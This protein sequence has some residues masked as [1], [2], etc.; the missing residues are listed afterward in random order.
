MYKI[1]YG[2]SRKA[3]HWKNSTITWSKLKERLQH[4]L[5]TAETQVEYAHMKSSGRSIAKDKGGFVAGELKDGQRKASTVVCRS[6]LT[7]DLDNAKTTF[8]EDYKTFSPYATLIYSTHS[9][10][11]ESPRLRMIIP[12]TREITPDE[13]Q[14]VTRLFAG[15]QGIGQFDPCSFIP[16]Q[17]MF[18][19]TVSNDGEYVFEE[20]EGEALD[21]DEFLSK[22][23]H[24]IRHHFP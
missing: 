15:E 21:P 5:R 4:P 9:H 1:A 22:Y 11:A 12:L 10:T 3:K 19:P 13:Y 6:M 20:V 17:L 2:E 14:A 24:E 23:P 7:M 16:S 18:W 8:L